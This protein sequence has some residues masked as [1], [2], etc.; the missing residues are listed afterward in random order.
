[1]KRIFDV[2][3][4][5][6]GLLFLFPVFIIVSM[7]IV[8]DSKGGVFF[9]Q[10]RVGRFGKDFRIHKFRTMFI[11]SEKKGRIT[12]GQDARVTRVGW[13]LR[14]YKIDELPQLI[15]VLSGTMSLVGP[16]PEVREFIDEYP[17]D[18]R[19]KVLSVRPGITDLASIEMV[20][21]NEILSSYDDPRRA[22]IDIILPIKQRYYL[23]YVANNSVK[24]DCVIIWKTIIKIL[25]R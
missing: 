12:V 14:K 23:D 22:Y 20:D 21:E 8:A 18:I 9:R 25:S 11:D 3:V 1:M 17:D 16:R 15:D 5:G 2:I 24:Y 19:E 6:L 10:Y 13:Y 4:A 7:L